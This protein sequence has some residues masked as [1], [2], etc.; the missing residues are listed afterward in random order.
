[1]LNNI[2]YMASPCPG[3]GDP[4]GKREGVAASLLLTSRW[5][6]GKLSMK[7]HVN[8]F[9]EPMLPT[10]NES[11]SRVRV[12]AAGRIVI[13]AEV[14]EHLQIKP[15]QELL[16]SEDGRGIHL[17]TFE[18]AVAAVQEMFA[19]YRV[20]GSSVVDELIREREDEAR[21]DRHE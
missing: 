1:M 18:Q 20:A 17:H 15:G 11:H 5:G 9:M 3:L 6:G 12:D 7:Y 13:P 10:G 4:T 14:R 8:N 16:L 2:L 19:S 21:H